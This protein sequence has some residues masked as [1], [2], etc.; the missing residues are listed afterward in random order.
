M[1]ADITYTLVCSRCGMEETIIIDAKVVMKEH[2]IEIQPTNALGVDGWVEDITK[3][4][5][6][7]EC[8]CSSKTALAMFHME[9]LRRKLHPTRYPGMSGKMVAILA[10]IL[11][12]SWT[13]PEIWSLSVTSDGHVVSESTYIGLLEELVN[14]LERLLSVAGLTEEEEEA[15]K[16]LTRYSLNS[17]SVDTKYPDWVNPML[18]R[19]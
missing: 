17:W 4:L 19:S 13:K 18:D 7:P 2:G 15:L 3:R 11:R 9:E 5:L 16:A 14:N 8:V 10:H 6:C 1:I 12:C